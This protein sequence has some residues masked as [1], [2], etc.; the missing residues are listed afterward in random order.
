[1]RFAG[2]ILSLATIS[3]LE[4]IQLIGASSDPPRPP[5]FGTLTAAMDVCLVA[6]SA[7]LGPIFLRRGWR[8]LGSLFTANLALMLGAFVLRSSGVEFSRAVL[9]GVGLYWLTLYLVGLSLGWRTLLGGPPNL[10]LQRTHPAAAVSA[11]I[12]GRSGGVVR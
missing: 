6:S 2:L 8:L 5:W 10:A 11:T 4:L 7:V 12:E 9:F 1:M 3:A